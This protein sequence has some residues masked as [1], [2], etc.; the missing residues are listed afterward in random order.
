[1]D[2]T[3][4]SVERFFKWL[5]GGRADAE[6]LYGELLRYN[7]YDPERVRLAVLKLSEGEPEQVRRYVEAAQ[8]DYRDVLAWAGYPEQ[9]RSGATRFNTS[10][11]EYEAILT[12]DRD[13]YRQW[14]ESFNAA[15]SA[16]E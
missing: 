13:Q 7:G 12:R 11:E 8:T 3:D 2:A 10:R 5:F 14:M 6:E 9:L 15:T 4:A 16:E 1:M